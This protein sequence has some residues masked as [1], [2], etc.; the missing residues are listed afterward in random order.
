MPVPMDSLRG[1]PGLL[2]PV[3]NVSWESTLK[4]TA[5]VLVLALAYFGAAKAG[6]LLAYE[7][8]SVTAVWAPTGIA[9][10]ALV[11]WGRGLWPGVALGAL[12]ANCWTGVPV[13][14]VLGIATGNTLE[15][16]VGASLLRVAGF[17]P[18]LERARDVLALAGLAA[19][20]S[21]VVSATVGVASLYAGDAISASA[22]DSAWRTWW[23]GD[24][25]GD[26]L[27]APFLLVFASGLPASSRR[28]ARSPH[29]RCC[30]DARRR[31]NIPNHRSRSPAA[32][33]CTGSAPPSRS[34]RTRGP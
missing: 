25:G 8:S 29:T 2:G 23:L 13:I 26:L 12:L 28:P 11:L 17:R 1:R 19:A 34:W 16:L 5:K 9:L 30:Q 32:S 10:A 31:R 20:L 6:L 27:V 18:S 24:V 33:L 7:N 4:Y 14:T 15:A 21:T 3:G 22:L